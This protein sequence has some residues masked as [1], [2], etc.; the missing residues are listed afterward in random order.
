MTLKTRLVFWF[1]GLA[2][3]FLLL[4]TLGNVL[5]PFIA[6]MALA[7]FMDP[8]VDRME[9]WGMSRTI[10][11]LVA[12]LLFFV[13]FLTILLLLV[14]LLHSQI[15]ILIDRMPDY[16]N[17]LSQRLEPILEELRMRFASQG[18]PDLSKLLSSSGTALS[19]A[20][21]FLGGLISGG[22]AFAN[23]VSLILITPIVAFYLLRDWDRMV[24]KID[25][26]LPRAQADTIRRL[27]REIDNT[28][29]GFV[30]G[31]AL[32]CL[33]L[34]TFY[35]VGL[36]L[37]G[38]D[39]G[40]IIGIF[41][42]IISFVPFVGSIAGGIAAIGLALVQFD[43]LVQV[44]LVAGVFVAGQAIEGNFLTP[45]MVGD[46][47]GLHPVWVIFALLAGGALF[48]FVGILVAVPVAAVLGVMTRF[49]VEQYLDS[50][51]YDE[52]RTRDRF[53]YKGD[54]DDSL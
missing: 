8:L 39:F 13:A 45:K 21:S 42:G 19:W 5:L 33:C 43:S 7:Y 24:A 17:T 44:A 47:V 52:N 9:R 11:T 1:G 25:G 36:T 48:G 32:V 29:A 30:R 26:W 18:D 6:G 34:G 10:G 40:L 16:I 20:A 53:D 41:A 4:Y 46:K 15:S 14:P 54:S 38:L 50:P 28:L 51:L 3:L 23:I 12:L 49:A 22:A 35:A 27:A 37:C 2:L 31:Q